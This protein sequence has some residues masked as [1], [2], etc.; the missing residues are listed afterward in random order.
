MTIYETNKG[1]IKKKE[2]LNGK[3]I[4]GREHYFSFSFLS[5]TTV[6]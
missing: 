4:F 2:M 3:Q 6:S 5:T 1:T